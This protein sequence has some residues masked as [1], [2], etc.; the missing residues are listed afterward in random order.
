MGIAPIQFRSFAWSTKVSSSYHGS[1]NNVRI[2]LSTTEFLRSVP[3]GVSSLYNQATGHYN[4][5]AYP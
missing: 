1:E 5:A 2:C 4:D 3:A